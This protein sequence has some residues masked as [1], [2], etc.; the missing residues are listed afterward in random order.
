MMSVIQGLW[1]SSVI[2]EVICFDHC[3]GLFPSDTVTRIEVM[4]RVSSSPVVLMGAWFI[5]LSYY[6]SQLNLDR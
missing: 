5:G 2:F 6:L 1:Q 3:N 4:E